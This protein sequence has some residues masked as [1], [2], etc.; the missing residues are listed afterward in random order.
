MKNRT[1]NLGRFP[2][3]NGLFL[4]KMPFGDYGVSSYKVIKIDKSDMS[5]YINDDG[6][7]LL[8]TVTDMLAEAVTAWQRIEIL[9]DAQEGNG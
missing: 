4:V 1:W 8:P 3:K 2:I 7:Y 9:K 5:V 6:P